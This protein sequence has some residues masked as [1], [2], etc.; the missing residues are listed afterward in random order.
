M[1][2]RRSLTGRSGQRFSGATVV[3]L[4]LVATVLATHVLRLPLTT[5]TL[6]RLSGRETRCDGN[7]Y[8]WGADQIRDPPSDPERLVGWLAF[9]L[10][11][12]MRSRINH[13]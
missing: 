8:A 5:T 7:D 9:D 11:P 10:E 2:R 12:R 1:H 3:L 6:S 13:G 4:G